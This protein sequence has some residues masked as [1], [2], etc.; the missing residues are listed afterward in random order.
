MPSDWLAHTHPSLPTG[1]VSRMVTRRNKARTANLSGFPL[2]FC[3]VG[4][5]A[6][7]LCGATG[8]VSVCPAQGIGP[9]ARRN[10]NP[11]LACCWPIGLAKRGGGGAENRLIGHDCL[12][13]ARVPSGWLAKRLAN[14]GAGRGAIPENGHDV[15]GMWGKLMEGVA[16]EHV[17]RVSWKW[18][19]VS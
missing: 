13:A 4:L 16:G 8:P 9:V 19:E 10:P 18:A 11:D 2:C 6:Q 3:C 17:K 1:A 12:L 15:G 5:R 14:K 7:C